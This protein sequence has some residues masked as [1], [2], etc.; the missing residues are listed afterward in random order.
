MISKKAAAFLG[1]PPGEGGGSSPL[2]KLPRRGGY[3][4]IPD[5]SLLRPHIFSANNALDK[6]IMMGYS[7]VWSLYFALTAYA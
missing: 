4:T 3:A 6:P 1:T 7:V 2:S 5:R